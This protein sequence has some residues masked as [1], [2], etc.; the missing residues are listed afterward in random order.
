[1]QAPT[2]GKRTCSRYIS[3]VLLQKAYRRTAFSPFA[4][5][6]PASTP[7]GCSYFFTE[8]TRY[9]KLICVHVSGKDVVDVGDGAWCWLLVFVGMSVCWCFS[10]CLHRG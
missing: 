2:K 4:D 8:L 3:C 1:M 5:I 10:Y 9:E 6:F 7:A